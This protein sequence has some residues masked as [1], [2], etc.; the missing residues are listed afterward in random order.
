MIVTM[1]A[2][3]A[4]IGF[5]TLVTIG[6]VGDEAPNSQWQLRRGT[7][8]FGLVQDGYLVVAVTLGSDGDQ[9]FFLQKAGSLF[10]CA[11]WHTPDVK[12]RTDNAILWCWELQP[13]YRV[14]Y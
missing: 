14:K 3:I 9:T 5:L 1:Y 2:R 12:K 6:A 13:P 7:S 11:D 4:A 10:K 8:L